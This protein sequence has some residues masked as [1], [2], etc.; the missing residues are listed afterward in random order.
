MSWQGGGP[1]PAALETMGVVIDGLHAY[2][3]W[4]ALYLLHYPA[5]W[6]ED[7]AT[8]APIRGDRAGSRTGTTQHRA[9]GGPARA[10]AAKAPAKR[11]RSSPALLPPR[12]RLV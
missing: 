12:T 10:T 3:R 4:L 9:T 7:N 2:R 6:Y 1:P 11:P 8:G 5:R